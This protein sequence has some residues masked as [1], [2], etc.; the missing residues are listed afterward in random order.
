MGQAPGDVKKAYAQTG[1]RR[2][3]GRVRAAMLALALA[4]VLTS[5]VGG[6]VFADEDGSATLSGD[7]LSA[8]DRAVASGEITL[9]GGAAQ[10]NA[11]SPVASADAA[12]EADQGGTVE[13][14]A[15]YPFPSFNPGITAG[16]PDAA[17]L[18]Q[19]SS[20]KAGGNI[21]FTFAGRNQ[22][23]FFN[24]CNLVDS[25]VYS[26]NPALTPALNTVA[27]IP[28]DFEDSLGRGKGY[29]SYYD[30]TY[31][32][33]YTFDG[34]SFT[35]T[36]SFTKAGAMW[37]KVYYQKW[38]V[39]ANTITNPTSGAIEPNP[40]QPRKWVPD[41][42]TRYFKQFNFDLLG[43]VNYVEYERGKTFK[44]LWVKNGSVYPK[45]TPKRSGF[46][47][48]GWYT[49]WPKGSKVSV[50]SAKIWFGDGYS[51]TLYVHWKKKVKI[52]FNPN[53]GKITKGKKVVKVNYLGKLGKAP[54]AKRSGYAGLGWYYKTKYKDSYGRTKTNYKLH[55]KSTVVNVPKATFSAEWL[56]NGS[57]KTV[58]AAE[59][60]RI[61][62]A[63]EK[64]LTIKYGA[65]KSAIGGKGM[66]NGETKVYVGTDG[67]Y[68]Y[69]IQCKEYEWNGT[70]SGTIVKMYFSV[71]TGNLINGTR[72]GGLK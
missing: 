34:P 50:G 25:K 21:T 71:K 68:N 49:A 13:A 57:K 10:L 43:V 52:T 53:K 24:S 51:K 39:V 65:V 30:Y 61:F 23:A 19:A 38:T 18:M 70:L 3:N 15:Y 63:Y 47:F 26:P 60:E 1:W 17:N 7:G 41:M 56:K 22:Q 46:K 33:D 36:N 54:T 4:L 69:Y 59:W 67:W 28:T 35:Y 20:N 27:Y 32:N 72:S 40:A 37:A 5:G 64:S 48:G 9:K 12:A 55:D 42:T 14:S 58:S 11:L 62:K 29:Y 6:S 45:L 31:I 16:A 8:L 2:T 44:T 66:Y